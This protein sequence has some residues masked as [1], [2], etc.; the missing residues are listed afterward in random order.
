MSSGVTA[1]INA[2]RSA[3]TFRANGFPGPPAVPLANRPPAWRPV[4]QDAAPVRAVVVS[5]FAPFVDGALSPKRPA[6]APFP[7]L[8]DVERFAPALPVSAT[9]GPFRPFVDGD[10]A[11]L[12]LADGSRVAVPAWP[13]S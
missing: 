7:P 1:S 12:P 6:P 2:D 9:V 4:G 3:A 8:G 13:L 5:P 11:A 10:A